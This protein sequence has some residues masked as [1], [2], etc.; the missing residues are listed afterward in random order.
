MK[1]LLAVGLLCAL[2]SAQV[3]VIKAG[4]LVDVDA[5]VLLADQTIIIRGGKIEAIE[6]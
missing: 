2:A 5:G 3:T 4:H 1:V 6:N